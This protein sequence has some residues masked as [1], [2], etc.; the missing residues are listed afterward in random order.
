MLIKLSFVPNENLIFCVD[1]FNYPV[2]VHFFYFCLF[3]DVSSVVNYT[4]ITEGLNSYL[5]TQSLIIPS[6]D[7][8]QQ[9]EPQQHSTPTRSPSGKQEETGSVDDPEEDIENSEDVENEEDMPVRGMLTGMPLPTGNRERKNP[10][11]GSN[12][13]AFN[14]SSNL[15]SNSTSDKLS[16]DVNLNVNEPEEMLSDSR[17]SEDEPKVTVTA[18]IKTSVLP[19]KPKP[20]LPKKPSLK[21]P[22]VVKAE[23][24]LE[25]MDVG[26]PTDINEIKSEKKSGASSSTPKAGPVEAFTEN[27]EPQGESLM[28]VSSASSVKRT[29]SSETSG[30]ETKPKRSKKKQ[31]CF[32]LVF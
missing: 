2:Y 25:L 1:F 32:H 8:E 12:K 22:P 3:A 31:V 5:N 19:D 7:P 24:A 29:E 21:E 10:P 20:P 15:I 30:S 18:E 9:E 13:Q 23:S 6:T 26:M 28:D 17:L 14:F 11:R 4:D 27:K 16:K